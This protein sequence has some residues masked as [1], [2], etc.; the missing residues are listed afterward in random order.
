MRDCVIN[1]LTRERFLVT[2]GAKL[3]FSCVY[4]P[5]IVGTYLY[6]W[7][8]MRGRFFLALWYEGFHG[9]PVIQL[10]YRDKRS[11][12]ATLTILLSFRCV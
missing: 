11:I 9:K 7:M 1:C 8:K 10:S 12:L 4:F 2:K 6:L 3:F 5:W